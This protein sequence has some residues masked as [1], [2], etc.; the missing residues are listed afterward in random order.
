MRPD[1]LV[2]DSCLAQSAREVPEAQLGDEV[3]EGLT[4]SRPRILATAATAPGYR[5]PFKQAIHPPCIK[6][7]SS[8]QAAT[9]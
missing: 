4:P 5:L 2:T 6:V 1:A 8:H 3:D 9:G 7:D